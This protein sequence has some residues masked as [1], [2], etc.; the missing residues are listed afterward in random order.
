MFHK[1]FASHSIGFAAWGIRKEL[2]VTKH[3]TPGKTKKKYA[4]L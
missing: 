1:P 4:D 2:N 3:E